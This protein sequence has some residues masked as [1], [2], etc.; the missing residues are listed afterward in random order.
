MQYT[1][2]QQTAALEKQLEELKGA[3]K[4]RDM[5]I[6]LSENKLF[7][8]L[9][10][11]EFCVKEAARYVHTSAD[12]SMSEANRADALAIAQ[13][14]GHLRRWLSVTVQ[15]GDHA[16]DRIEEMEEAIA[17]SRAEEAAEAE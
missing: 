6:K 2:A 15:M 3:V 16:K 12:P 14:G 4:L 10:L 8:E 1:A 9:I 7:K 11:E 5:A 13:S 17:A